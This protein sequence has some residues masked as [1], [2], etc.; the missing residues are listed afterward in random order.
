MKGVSIINNQV[1]LSYGYLKA[2]GIT[3]KQLENWSYRKV[4]Q[5]M[6]INGEKHVL[7]DSIPEAERAEHLPTQQTIISTLNAQA[8]D[9]KVNQYIKAFQRCMTVDF[10]KYRKLYTIY[11]WLKDEKITEYA[12]LHA[13]FTYC[14]EDRDR[15]SQFAA[16][17]TL[18]PAKYKC[19]QVFDNK[20]S[21]FKKEGHEAAIVDMR[22]VISSQN[23]KQVAQKN[24]DW[25]RL[26]VAAPQK[27]SASKIHKLI[28]KNCEAEGI[29]PPSLA[30]VALQKT[31]ILRTSLKVY[32]ARY[33]A[34]QAHNDLMPK[35]T[36]LP[37]AYAGDQFQVDGWTI[38]LWYKENGNLKRL[39]MCVV[40]DAHSKKAV[41]VSV[42]KSENSTMIIE[43]LK[44]AVKNTG[45]VPFEYVM[46]KSCYTRTKQH[47]LF[48]A[49][50]ERK[51]LK[52]TVD[53]N[54]RRKSILERSFQ[55]LDALVRDYYGYLGK[56][57]RSK[58]ID[59]LP[60]AE[61]FKEYAKNP[62]TIDQIT[63]IAHAIVYDYNNTPLPKFDKT[64]VELYQQSQK[65]NCIQVSE[66]ERHKMVTAGKAY[67]A[68]QGQ[69]TIQ[70]DFAE[71]EFMLPTN[72]HL[73]YNNR[74]VLV[75]YDNLQEGICLY[76]A[77]SD[78]PIGYGEPKK[79]MHGAKANQTSEDHKILSEWNQ[80]QKA[81]KDS[82]TGN[83][84][85]TDYE[86]TLLD[87]FAKKEIAQTAREMHDT[88]KYLPE[89]ATNAA[90]F[91][92]QMDNEDD[93]P[94]VPLK[95]FDLNEFLKEDDE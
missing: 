71:Y 10:I 38:P 55:N 60:S 59:A 64:P 17:Q 13:I 11:P 44:D 88:Q 92:V 51:G 7:Y 54:P 84:L 95:I 81:I 52:V 31:E 12:Q 66:F 36:L 47:A 1:W 24:C 57:I 62:L 41:G 56:G 29:T 20:K 26:Y 83:D 72:V 43:A 23:G 40:M 82:D 77:D 61:Q 6:P 49:A 21:K 27:L 37:A 30:W 65:P 32:K 93:A 86:H 45:V 58:T 68:V 75:R 5:K 2:N 19:Q 39:T 4:S 8:H 79:L 15:I 85:N 25:V 73:K 90:P 78:E 67:K 87:G 28:C 94:V 48:V 46:D 9:T 80:R 91:Y 14:M 70:K 50:I 33:G 63:E 74:P 76:D 16:F 34:T 42:D 22:P 69:I 53:T 89:N 35:M 18:F 3:Q